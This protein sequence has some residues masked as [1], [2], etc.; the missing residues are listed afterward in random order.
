MA[1]ARRAECWNLTRS[2]LHIQHLQGNE[3]PGRVRRAL[4]TPSSPGFD[5]VIYKSLFC[6][7]FLRRDQS[8]A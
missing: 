7:D 4:I 2:L 6:N 3:V 1:I 8:Q 5:P